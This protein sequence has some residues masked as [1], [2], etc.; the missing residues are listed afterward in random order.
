MKFFLLFL[1][2]K[3]LRNLAGSQ[4][5]HMAVEEKTSCPKDTWALS[6]R[7]LSPLWM[8][9]PGCKQLHYCIW[10]LSRGQRFLFFY[11]V[12][13]STT[14]V[15]IIELKGDFMIIWQF[16][17]L[18]PNRQNAS[19]NVVDE[20]HGIRARI[21]SLVRCNIFHLDKILKTQRWFKKNKDNKYTDVGS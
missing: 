21:F 15:R 9:P 11:F 1:N 8:V 7:K 6:A 3:E 14:N 2:N 4:L 13:L 10:Q 12:L 18:R 5:V 16:G 19:S 17:K 20:R